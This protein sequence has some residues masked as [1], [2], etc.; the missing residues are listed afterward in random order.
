MTAPGQPLRERTLQLV[1]AQL[2][3][4]GVE[5]VPTFGDSSS[6]D[7]DA[8]LFT[9]FTRGGPIGQKGIFGCGRP[10]NFTGYCQRLVTS[11]LD[12][13]DRILD[14]DQ[15]ARVL[16]RVDGQLAKDVPVIPLYD[17]PLLYAFR[18]TIN[19]VDPAP[20]NPFW[21]AENWWLGR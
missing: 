21:K 1:Q 3:R 13:A 19:G 18:T 16:N 8:H 4:A 10:Q 20:F 9:W 6:G 7:F 5:V 12:Q 11:D 2:R 14:A 17:V 15:R